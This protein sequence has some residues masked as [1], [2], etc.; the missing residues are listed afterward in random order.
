MS[1]LAEC[2]WCF[3]RSFF[4][5]ELLMFRQKT[6]KRLFFICLVVAIVTF[7]VFFLMTEPTVGDLVILTTCSLILSTPFLTN[8]FSK[9]ELKNKKRITKTHRRNRRLE[10]A[11]PF[12][13]IRHY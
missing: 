5:E 10:P 7:L 8:A 1:C 13:T 2:F 9:N 4:N 3:P 6:K 12:E 11:A